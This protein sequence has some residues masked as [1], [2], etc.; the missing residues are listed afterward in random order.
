VLTNTVEQLAGF[1]PA[2]LAL[3]A[4]VASASMRFVVAAAFVFAL[5]RSVFWAGYLVGPLMRAPGM[6]ATAAINVG[7][8]VAAI[9]VWW[10]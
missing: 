3:A 10:P 4:G 7:T 8:L 1:V 2:L 9:F 6:A 5:A